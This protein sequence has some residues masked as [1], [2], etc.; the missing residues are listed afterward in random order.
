MEKDKLFKEL[1]A[2]KDGIEAQRVQLK[3]QKV[4]AEDLSN[5]RLQGLKDVL[6]MILQEQFQVYKVTSDTD[7]ADMLEDEPE[8]VLES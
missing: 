2:A 4:A 3:L 1:E 6:R 7:L 5:K 8:Q